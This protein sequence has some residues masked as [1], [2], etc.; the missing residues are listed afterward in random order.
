MNRLASVSLALLL[1]A[2][3]QAQVTETPVP[4]DSSGRVQ[5]ITPPLASRLGLV[6]P[7]WPVEGVY[8]EV[9]LYQLGTGFVLAAARPNGDHPLC[10]HR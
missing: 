2:N 7:S 10:N 4:F 5:S 8:V 6:P 9:R 1:A 3:A